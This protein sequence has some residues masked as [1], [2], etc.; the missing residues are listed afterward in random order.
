MKIVGVIGLLLAVVALGLS[1]AVGYRVYFPEGKPAGSEPFVTR[2]DL[3]QVNKRLLTLDD[4]LVDLEKGLERVKSVPV[5]GEVPASAIISLLT[6]MD[7]AVRR[8]SVEILK[9]LKDPLCLPALRK[10]AS[11]D[12]DASVRSGAFSALVVFGGEEARNFLLESLKNPAI[13]VRRQAIVGLAKVGKKEDFAVLADIFEGD[14]QKYTAAIRSRSS[15]YSSNNNNIRY[16]I[17]TMIALDPDRSMSYVM[18]ALVVSGSDYEI[19]R[20]LP[21][22]LSAKNLPE[23]LKLATALPKPT[24]TISSYGS[25]NSPQYSV[26]SAL[27]KLND[28]RA[29]PY[30]FTQLESPNASIQ[31]LAIR[32]LADIGGDKAFEPIAA[33]FKKKLAEALKDKTSNTNYSILGPF[34]ESFRALKDKR[35]CALLVLA[36][37]L[38]SQS[39]RRS[40]L[41]GLSSIVD[42]AQGPVIYKIWNTTTDSDLKT[43]LQKVL[44]G[45]AGY[46]Y[47]WDKEGATFLQKK[48]EEKIVF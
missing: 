11:K 2:S 42:P 37:P 32:V 29:I 43:A 9:S 12:I 21:K 46:G 35:A 26:L 40:V 16:L 18:R 24:K 41:Y 6:H 1:M 36:L 47:I 4:K 33:I 48:V 30:V 7:P 27:R 15:S 39:I 25:S 34:F 5:A 10:T 3:G 45:N 44:T 14:L 20:S 23:M 19:R 17:Q 38:K 13:D 8:A 31:A 28:K 22:T